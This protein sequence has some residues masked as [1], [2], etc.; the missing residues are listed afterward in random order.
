MVGKI[1]YGIKRAITSR[2][3]L[4]AIIVMVSTVIVCKLI[5]MT[6]AALK[7]YFELLYLLFQTI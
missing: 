6:I 2:S 5:V 7:P 1:L 3:V 4:G